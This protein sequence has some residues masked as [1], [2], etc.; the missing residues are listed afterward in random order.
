[1]LRKSDRRALAR[2]PI[3]DAAPSASPHPGDI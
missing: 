1:M 3:G 2:A